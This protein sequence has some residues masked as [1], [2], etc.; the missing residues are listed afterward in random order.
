[1]SYNCV[2]KPN[3]LLLPNVPYNPQTKTPGS[4][5]RVIRHSRTSQKMSS[6]L[7]KFTR[8]MTGTGP[9]SYFCRDETT[10]QDHRRVQAGSPGGPR[11]PSP[12]RA[13]G[14]QCSS[15][16]LS[17]LS[18]RLPLA[19]GRCSPHVQKTVKPAWGEEGEGRGR[20]SKKP[21]FG[22]LAHLVDGPS[23]READC[24]G[25]L[26]QGVSPTSASGLKGRNVPA[27]CLDL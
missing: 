17:S 8:R 26:G 16:T 22:V 15:D 4:R 25:P 2:I 5:T 20:M 19:R 7:L 9:A 3:C 18:E 11:P 6:E 27:F 14:K 21:F 1:M 10:R 24:R 13:R 12:Q 23:Y